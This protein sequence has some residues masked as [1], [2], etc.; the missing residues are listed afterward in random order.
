VTGVTITTIRQLTALS[1]TVN[2]TTPPAGAVLVTLDY[3]A[4][5][6]HKLWTARYADGTGTVDSDVQTKDGGTLKIYRIVAI[7]AA[8]SAPSPTIGG[9]VTLI[10]AQVREDSGYQVFTRTWA[11]GNGLAAD[12]KTISESGALV[13]YH[14]RAYGTPPTTPSA[15]IGGT[16]TLFEQNVTQGDGIVIYDYRWAEGDGQASITTQ[17]ESDGA[18]VYTVTDFNVAATTPA[19]PGSGTA[20]LISLTQTPQAGFFRNQAVYKKPPATVTFQKSVTFSMPGLAQFTGT[21]PQLVI[22]S[23]VSMKILADVEVSYGTTQITD[24]PFTVEAYA[25]LYY[26]YIEDATG[27]PRSTTDALGG[28]LA[29]ASSISGT[30]DFFNGVLCESY[31]ATLISSTPSA[32]PTGLTVIDTDNDPYLVTTAGVVVYRRM[33]ISYTF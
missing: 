31:E 28:Y 20:Y 8:P 24:T 5:D 26:A 15:T 12:D 27:T 13:V 4:Q 21:P 7:N 33:K 22:A 2:P 29:G 16:V 32:R 10:D 30:N 14:R 3:A 18:L 9:T 11:E 6:G 25:S 19:Y 23:P 17:G 1:V